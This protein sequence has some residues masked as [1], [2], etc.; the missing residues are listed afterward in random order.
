[1]RVACSGA[2]PAGLYFAI[3]AKRRDP[4]DSV[5]V[6]E[7]QPESAGY[8]WGVTFLPALLQRLYASDPESARDIEEATFRWRDQF[9]EIHGAR[10]VYDGGV[11]VY[12]LSRP[13]LVEILAARA[14]QLGVRIEYGRDITTAGQLPEA[15][16]IVAADGAGSP[17][18]QSA[19]DF[20]TSV[21]QGDD[22]YIW[23]GTDRPFRAFT[24]HFRDTD[25]GWI[26]ASSYG[27]EAEL[28]TF[29]VHCAGA[30]WRGLGFDAL[31]AA[32]TLPLVHKLYGEQLAGYRLMGQ[33]GDEA[34]AQWKSF[35]TVTNQR[36]HQGNVVLVGDS[37][38]TTHFT[39][40]EGTTLA[41]EDAIALAEH[42][43]RPGTIATALAAYE[44]QRQAEL[45]PLARQAQLSARFFAG[46]PRYAGL[47]PEQFTTLL[48]ARRSRLLPLLPPR[49]YGTLRRASREAPL[50]RQ[51][52]P[53]ARALKHRLRPPADR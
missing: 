46:I 23:L 33:P 50:L 25:A 34:G 19:G 21:E 5:T 7:K 9:V 18:R 51:A 49:V 42:L 10:V 41:L 4:R 17:L 52:R 43:G 22:K 29:V 12:N 2:G 48:H 30:T 37:A 11:D 40:G 14:R 1:V 27:I 15:D 24:Y 26:W 16:L 53:A 44:R 35:R 39:T 32:E 36:W 20:G 45:R 3:L 47:P 8:G 38:H 28:S 6:Y 13:R 31:P